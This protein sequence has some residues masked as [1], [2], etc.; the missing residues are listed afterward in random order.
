MK[1]TVLLVILCFISFVVFAGVSTTQADGGANRTDLGYGIVVN[2]A[3]TL[4]REW[5]ALNDTSMGVVFE[6]TPG[7]TTS[8]SKSYLYKTSYSIKPT[9]DLSAINVV[10]VLYDVFGNHISNLSTLEVQDLREGVPYK[11]TA[12]W[13][14]TENNV[15]RYLY[16]IAY[17]SKA[18]TASGKV[19]IAD[20]EP[21]IQLALLISP[22]SKEEDFSTE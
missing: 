3:S 8:Y 22:N 13:S 17:V 4:H 12:Q 1:K 16:C 6:G 19:Y 18:R 14:A 11:F 2:S 15:S 20:L 9:E 7:I 21:V 5:Y 10:F